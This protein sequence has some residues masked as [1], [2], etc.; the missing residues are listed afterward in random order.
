[1]IW[2]PVEVASV[3]TPA[4]VQATGKRR[5]KRR[6]QRMGVES[7]RMPL[8]SHPFTTDSREPSCRHARPRVLPRNRQHNIFAEWSCQTFSGAFD[9]VNLVAVDGQDLVA[10]LDTRRFRF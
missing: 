10:R 5:I 1:M 3:E 7:T 9:R 6:R 2:P 4:L 8:A